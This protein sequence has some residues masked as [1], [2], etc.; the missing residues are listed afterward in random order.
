MMDVSWHW[1]TTTDLDGTYSDL[2]RLRRGYRFLLLVGLPSM[3]AGVLATVGTMVVPLLQTRIEGLGA[4]S[5][6][7]AP[8]VLCCLVAAESLTS[9]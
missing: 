9:G 4:I 6:R 2:S 8:Y 5:W 3:L 7:Y 1:R